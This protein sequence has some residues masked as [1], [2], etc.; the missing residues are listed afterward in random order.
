MSVRP[1]FI[2]KQPFK[3]WSTVLLAFHSIFNSHSKKY[4]IRYPNTTIFGIAITSTLR[5]D[6]G[7]TPEENEYSLHE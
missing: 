3:S 5:K 7:N 2:D 1:S 6:F 4:S